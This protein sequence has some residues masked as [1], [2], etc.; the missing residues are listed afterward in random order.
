M[1]HID[2]FELDDPFPAIVCRGLFKQMLK[3][4]NPMNIL[5]RETHSDP[6]GLKV[7]LFVSI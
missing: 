1:G 3:R 6:A 5:K 2:P 4:K 7:A